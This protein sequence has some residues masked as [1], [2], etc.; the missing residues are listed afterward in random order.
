MCRF[1]TFQ[2]LNPGI[3]FPVNQKCPVPRVAIP[4]TAFSD[5]VD[6]G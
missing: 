2:P 5:E 1:L 4:G 6:R 3:H